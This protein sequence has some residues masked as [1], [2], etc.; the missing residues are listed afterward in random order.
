MSK[1]VAY[2]KLCEIMN[3]ENDESDSVTMFLIGV[4]KTLFYLQ[5]KTERVCVEDLLDLL[6]PEA[7]SWDT[8]PQCE[9]LLKESLA[10]RDREARMMHPFI[11]F[12]KQV[13]GLPNLLSLGTDKETCPICTKRQVKPNKIDQRQQTA[14]LIEL[15]RSRDKGV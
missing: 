8:Y 3:A 12:Q 11:S 6:V 7:P 10:L 2:L 9:A 14:K 5:D 15:A 13:D 1:M 4:E